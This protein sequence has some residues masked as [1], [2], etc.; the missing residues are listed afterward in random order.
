MFNVMSEKW[1][2]GGNMFLLFSAMHKYAHILA[3]YEKHYAEVILMS[4]CT[5]MPCFMEKAAEEIRCV[6]DDI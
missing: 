1:P 6:F 4:T 5:H 3:T 2:V